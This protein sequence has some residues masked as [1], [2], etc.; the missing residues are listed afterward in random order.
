M[1]TA[2]KELFPIEM[3]GISVGM[4]NIF[5]F[6]GGMISQPLIGSLL[7]LMRGPAG[8][9]PVKAYQTVFLLFIVIAG[10]W[11]IGKT[12]ER[13]EERN[14]PWPRCRM[15]EKRATRGCRCVSIPP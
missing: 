7:D 14:Q 10:L 15:R 9:Q 6:L 3:A 11:C 5:P 12:R 8:A 1:I 2:T 13:R 4:V